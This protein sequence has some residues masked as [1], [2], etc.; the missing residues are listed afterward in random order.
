MSIMSKIVVVSWCLRYSYE[1]DDD[2]DDNNNIDV[3][4]MT[5]EGDH[6]STDAYYLMPCLEGDDEDPIY[7][8]APAA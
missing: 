7:D 6:D 8:Y 5:N 2:S 1:K 3:A 4:W